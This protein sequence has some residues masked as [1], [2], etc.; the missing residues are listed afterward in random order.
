MNR[1]TDAQKE[2]IRNM[3]K[4][5]KSHQEISAFMKTTYN[6][7]INSGTISY[8]CGGSA[9]PAA[10]G[11][12]KRKYT[13]HAA[14]KPQGGVNP[15]QDSVKSLVDQLCAEL[16]AYSKHVIRQVRV[17][18]VKRIGEARAK[19]IDAGEKVLPIEEDNLLEGN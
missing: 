17:E 19:R 12:A 4:D 7:D 5:G 3:A 11:K 9:K 16:D 14:P 2:Q 13:R 15:S 1:Y 6:L 8:I 18:L 10:S